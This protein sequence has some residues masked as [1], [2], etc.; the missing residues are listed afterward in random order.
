MKALRF[1]LRYLT[2]T[3][4]GAAMLSACNKPD[5]GIDPGPGPDPIVNP[6]SPSVELTIS[7][8]NLIFSSFNGSAEFTITTDQTSWTVE[9]N[10][11]WISVETSGSTVTVVVQDNPGNQDRQGSITVTAGGKKIV[12]PINQDAG[13]EMPTGAEDVTVIYTLKEGAVVAP[14]AFASYIIAH[15]GEAN[16]LTLRKD[17]P[18]ELIPA[19][20]T[21]L[22]INT[23][24]EALPGGLLARFGD[25]EETADGI[26]LFYADL[27]L[28]SVFKDLDINLEEMDLGAYITRAEDAE[29]NE[30]Q[31]VRT[32]AAT[33]QKFH[34]D[35]PTMGWDLPLGFTL[36]PKMGLDIALKLQMILGDYK[37]S[38]LN[39]KVDLDATIG[40]DLELALEGS[41]DKYFKILTLYFAAIPLGP[42]VVTPGVDIYGFVGADG[43]IGMTSSVS[44][45][46]HT[47]S[48]LHYDEINGLSGETKTEDPEPEETKYSAGPKIEAG[49]SYGL[50]V[51]PSIGLFT[52]AM[53]VGVTINLKRRES[54]ST[55]FDLISLLEDPN[56]HWLGWEYLNADY[57]VNWEVNTALHLRGF[58]YGQDYTL[59]GVGL[60]E[61]KYKLF[62][63]VKDI[64]LVQDGGGFVVSANVSGPSLLPGYTGATLGELVLRLE[65]DGQP[66]GTQT[67]TFDLNEPMAQALWDEPGSTQ[68]IQAD[69]DGLESGKEYRATLGWRMGNEYVPLY[70]GYSLLALDNNTLQ[71]IR[72]IL[73]DI[74][75]CADGQWEG[76]NWNEPD[77]TVALWKENGLY[78]S[79]TAYRNVD[80]VAYEQGTLRLTID[81]P[82][83][84]KL[85]NNLIVDN[86]T[87]N[88]K[89]ID[90][91]L[92]LEEGQ[93]FD[94]ISIDEKSFAGMGANYGYSFNAIRAKTYI[95]HSPKISNWWPDVTE[96]LDLSGS[97][98][99]YLG[100][101][102]PL[103]IIVDNCP[104][105]QNI[106]LQPD[107]GK[108][109]QSFSAQNC[110]ALESLAL[111]D[112]INISAAA[113]ENMI[114]TVGNAGSSMRLY[115][116][117]NSS[118]ILDQLTIGKGVSYIGELKNV[119][120]LYLS[121]ATDLETA[122]IRSGVSNLSVS[123]CPKLDCL[124]ARD[125]G[126]ESFSI[127]GTPALKT[128][129]ISYND[130]LNPTIVPAV[131]EQIKNSDGDLRYDERF[132]YKGE[133]INDPTSSYVDSQGKLWIK[134]VWA[135]DE[136]YEDYFWYH[137][138][139]YGFYYSGE[140]ERSYHT[141]Q[142]YRSDM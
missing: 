7:V 65:K 55:G 120:S 98:V 101:S 133:G 78:D 66:L 111:Y 140:P 16:T 20:G 99:S 48:E 128:L 32:K 108:T 96:K 122:Y 31:F 30:V 46:L 110:P 9:S 137:D 51:G 19:P 8:D 38:T 40:A 35:L 47:H 72:G 89:N 17:I 113:I 90:W 62:P 69:I 117:L 106:I 129:R 136:Y 26:V 107:E 23:P 34:I 142:H 33:Q 124:V 4:L 53:Q 12:I 25:R 49:I 42:V 131:F 114:A 139:G 71:T 83:E 135:S 1:L 132:E 6:P 102:D 93:D 5:P 103:E 14:K 92:G 130:K 91:V 24:T 73:G 39:F 13:T 2:V 60:K 116:Y 127:T 138:K 21:E 123:D 63:P 75:A 112:D 94:T 37:I 67:A 105:L 3:I 87:G 118:H 76:C 119:R 70:G 36:T 50:G 125:A 45:V 86:H 80:I 64:R 74:R 52:D 29:G 43:K 27:D 10:D 126:L 81:L 11:D 68:D 84:W 44:T 59:P 88:I 141:G 61:E 109:I 115:L 15:D 97:G 104:N 22:I 100:F 85:G 79:G 54:L 134:Y 121:G 95:C 56:N 58:G 82:K 41:V 18:R 77:L 28:T 57:I